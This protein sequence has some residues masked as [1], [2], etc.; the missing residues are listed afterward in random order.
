[1][2][3]LFSATV[4]APEDRKAGE[5]LREVEPECSL[6]SLP[7]SGRSDF[8][9]ALIVGFGLQPSRRGPGA[10]DGGNSS[11]DIAFNSAF[12]SGCTDGQ[13]QTGRR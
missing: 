12:N 2:I 6:A 9:L 13:S 11:S 5:I 1:V 7:T 4:L 3:F 8:S 10:D